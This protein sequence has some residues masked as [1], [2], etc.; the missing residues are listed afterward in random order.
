MSDVEIWVVLGLAGVVGI[1]LTQIDESQPS[2]RA[3]TVVF[4]VSLLM[5]AVIL[6]FALPQLPLS[7]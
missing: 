2:R 5:V 4:A 3:M 1:A 6:G 7:G